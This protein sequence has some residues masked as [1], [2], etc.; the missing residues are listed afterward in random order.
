M[1]DTS[2]AGSGNASG[3]PALS[4][5]TGF[6]DV[7]IIFYLICC[8]L[9]SIVYLFIFFLFTI[10]LFIIRFTASDCPFCILNFVLL[11]SSYP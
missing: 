7:R 2:E 6:N 5:P 8:I 3:G 9:W 10:V 1:S 11:L 4:S